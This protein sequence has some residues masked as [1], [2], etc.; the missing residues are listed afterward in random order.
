MVKEKEMETSLGVQRSSFP[1][2]WPLEEKFVTAEATVC[3]ALRLLSPPLAAQLLCPGRYSCFAGSQLR[4]PQR[5]EER[6]PVTCEITSSTLA[7]K[8]A[9]APIERRNNLMRSSFPYGRNGGSF[10]LLH[11]SLPPLRCLW[12]KGFEGLLTIFS[13]VMSTVAS[14][15]RTSYHRT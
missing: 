3:A 8:W 1:F 10:F 15:W 11:M 9:P 7:R 13:W 6:W 12:A 14:S 2:Q 4:P 5:R